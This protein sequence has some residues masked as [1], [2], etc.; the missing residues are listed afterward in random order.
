MKKTIIGSV[1]A[2]TAATA[3]AAVVKQLLPDVMRYLRIR[4]M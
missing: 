2:A 3:V 1:A 4:K